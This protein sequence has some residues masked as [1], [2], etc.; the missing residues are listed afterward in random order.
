M[1][2]ERPYGRVRDRD[3]PG[4]GGILPLRVGEQLGE[5]SMPDPLEWSAADQVSARTEELAHGI[6][7]QDDEALGVHDEHALGH[8]VEDSLEALLLPCR[9]GEA[10]AQLFGQEL[11]G[12]CDLDRPVIEAW[13]QAGG[14]IPLGHCGR[15]A[16]QRSDGP[17][18]SMR[19]ADRYRQGGQQ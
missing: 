17:Q 14:G 4:F 10:L 19:E 3:D 13:G 1:H 11:D 18:R 8:A 16:P 6:V 15:E 12:A 9:F 7:Y 2:P 5:V